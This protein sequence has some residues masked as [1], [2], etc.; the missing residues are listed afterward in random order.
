MNHTE[1]DGIGTDILEIERIR[2]MIKKHGERMLQRLFTEKEIHYCSKFKDPAP[3]LTG[4]FCA[5][6][7]V[8]KALGTGFGKTLSFH[9][10]EICNNKEGK[11]V[12]LLSEKLQKKIG[13]VHILLS[14]SHCKEYAIATAVLRTCLK[15]S[16][17]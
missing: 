7:A 8:S 13:T 17:G 12:V 9:D 2:L 6:E 1:I 5:K 11:P 10:I 4:R 3:H 16:I 14:I 15:S